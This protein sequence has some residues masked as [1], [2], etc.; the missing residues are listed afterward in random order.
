[1]AR[2]GRVV[3]EIRNVQKNFIQINIRQDTS[4]ENTGFVSR[5]ILKY[6]IIVK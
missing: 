3:G 4:F 5:A 6:L 2:R 1:L